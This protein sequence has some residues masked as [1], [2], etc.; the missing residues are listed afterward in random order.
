LEDFYLS[1]F[2]GDFINK[3]LSETL[4]HGKMQQ[5]QKPLEA[6]GLSLG[7]RQIDVYTGLNVLILLLELHRFAQIPFY[8]CG[9][10][11][12]QC[13]DLQ[14]CHW[15]PAPN[16][17]ESEEF[18]P[19]RMLRLISYSRC[20]GAEVFVKTVGSFL[21][22]INLRDTDLRGLDLYRVKLN[23]SYISSAIL[24]GINLSNADLREVFLGNAKLRR[25][26]LRDTN[27]ENAF[28]GNADL[29]DAS[30]Q[31]VKLKNAVLTGVNF[32]TAFLV[33]A[34]LSGTYLGDA[35][36]SDANLR[37]ANLQNADLSCA[38]LSY[39][40]LTGAN[41]T[42]ANLKNTNLQ[43][44]FKD[45]KTTWEIQELKKAHLS[46]EWRKEIEKDVSFPISP[47]LPS[48]SQ[49]KLE[50]LLVAAHIGGTK[51]RLCLVDP[52]TLSQNSFED[53]YETR[54]A[55][56]DFKDPVPLVQ[57]FL[58]DARKY[59]NLPSTPIPQ[60][61]CLA[62]AGPVEDNECRMTHLN[63]RIDGNR[64]A[65]K[66]GMEEGKLKLINDFQAVAYGIPRLQSYDYKTLQEVKPEK[67]G[68]IAVIGAATGL[69][70]SFLPK[71]LGGDLVYATE[72][73]HTDFTRR[74]DLEFELSQYILKQILDENN[75]HLEQVAVK[76]V[77]SGR[78]IVAI[79]RFLRDHPQKENLLKKYQEIEDSPQIERMIKTWQ[80]ED[81][82]CREIVDPAAVIAAGALFKRDRLCMKTMQMFV[83]AY[84]A[85]VGNFALQFLPYGGLYV[86]GGITAQILPLILEGSFLRAFL[87]KGRM[88]EILEKIPV[89]VIKNLNVG[90]MGAARYAAEKM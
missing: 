31:N 39:A 63:L 45:E 64:L 66:L 25:A 9:K 49:K 65:Q 27:I 7:W 72:G 16:T 55:I 74:T 12:S 90:L 82:R 21:E 79:Y 43:D 30:L 71:Q 51:A 69:G 50:T 46:D 61:A 37:G 48:R 8:P 10:P 24:N 80:E 18:D 33:N 28:L 77:V 68:L 75:Q 78:G 76:R 60:K 26:D 70:K 87:N 19:S 3:D 40:N 23:Q 22:G 36:L 86:A 88:K 47:S 4:P 20:L 13:A 15:E 17:S 56:G 5:L 32:R 52:Q 14:Q 58:K 85:E 44:I 11:I 84:G 35:D 62:V 89:Y 38:N 59:L 67:D 2:K 41:L 6:Q 42:G 81:E 73:G 29:R 53:L 34:D 1:W 54:Y 83:E 57:Q